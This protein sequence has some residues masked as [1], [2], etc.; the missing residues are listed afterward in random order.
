[1]G[2]GVVVYSLQAS[3]YN[4]C[5]RENIQEYFHRPWR[6]Y[7]FTQVVCIGPHKQRSRNFLKYLNF[8]KYC[9]S[10]ENMTKK[11]PFFLSHKENKAA[12]AICNS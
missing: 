2:G 8:P 6:Y 7:M 3:L 1:M 10:F 4:I 12:G 11:E 5:I 9:F